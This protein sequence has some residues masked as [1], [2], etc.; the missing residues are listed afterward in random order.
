MSLWFHLYILQANILKRYIAD[1]RHLLFFRRVSGIALICIAA[2]QALTASAEEIYQWKDENG[3][4]HFSDRRPANQKA[5]KIDPIDVNIDE[6]S[7]HLD[8]APIVRKN[9]E[10]NTSSSKQAR[11]LKQA[12]SEKKRAVWCAEAKSYHWRLQRRV[13]F[14][15]Q[16]GQVIKTSWAQKQQ[17]AAKYKQAIAKYC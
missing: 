14:V 12:E 6:S 7:R 15:D 4:T 10:N 1:A 9:K 3:K 16:K 13:N 11:S 17:Y 5:E 8:R 2:G